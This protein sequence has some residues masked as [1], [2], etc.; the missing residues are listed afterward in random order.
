M[1][2]RIGRLQYLAGNTLTNVV[3]MGAGLAMLSVAPGNRFLAF[4]AFFFIYAPLMGVLTAWR[5]NDL[6]KQPSDAVFYVL[7]PVVNIIG[8]IEC[9]FYPAP[10]EARRQQKI[11]LWKN[12]LGPFVAL[13]QGGALMG[14]TASVGLPL[15]L[16]Y[17]IVMAVGAD[18]AVRLLDWGKTA[19]PGLVSGLAD[20]FSV[21]AVILLVY[22]GLQYSKRARASRISWV[23][24]LFL[25]PSVLMA[26]GFRFF[27]A[28]NQSQLQLVLILAFSMAW[29]AVWMSFGGAGFIA[30]ITTAAEQARK[31]E[32]VDTG[33]AFSA[34]GSR[35][36]DVAG[37]H[38]TRVQAIMVGNQV[39][40]PGIFYMLQLAFADTI[41]VLKPEA[42]AL[43]ESGRLTWG[44]RGRLFKMFLTVMLLTLIAQFG[45]IVLIDG[46]G[47][48]MAY[49][50]DPRE[51]SL[52]G[53]AA[54]EIVWGLSAWWVQ[55]AL[56]LVYH[57][58]VAYLR[59]RTA[60]RK[61]AK[62]AKAAKAA[63]DAADATP[64]DAV[65]AS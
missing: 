48:A 55:L 13:A 42:S 44:M 45:A 49:F 24:S 52:G 37:P 57:D 2:R 60:A 25:L 22:T 14:R 53:Y 1:D 47:P 8:L 31:G 64:A 3:A 27:D 63:A 19:D 16:I 39:V 23:P 21:L 65:P 58:R 38:G 34:V 7:V 46:T 20:G 62:A 54:S 15:A 4:G 17:G 51:L 26:A 30:G 61:E 50:F 32:P 12:Q 6:G 18:R 29:S 36:L 9:T 56:L 5:L 35:M 59:A 28:G 40:I 10:S 43:K 41:A 11:H 33:A